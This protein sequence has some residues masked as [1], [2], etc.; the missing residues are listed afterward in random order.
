MKIRIAYLLTLVGLAGFA[1]LPAGQAAVASTL[2]VDCA[3]DSGALAAAL[4]SA[5]DGD[6]LAIQGVCKGAF[7]IAHSLTLAGGAA[8]TLDGQG[9]GTVLSID[10]GNSVVVRNL[11]ITGGHDASAGGVRNAG[12]LSLANSRVS[13]NSAN[14][15]SGAAFFAAGGILNTGALAVENSI[16]T[17]NSTSG[18]NFGA[19]AIASIAGSLRLTNS[20]VSGNTATVLQ[21]RNGVAGIL[22]FSSNAIVM[23]SA[24]RGNIASASDR[25]ST[26]VGGI[27]NASFNTSVP[28]SFKLINST[29]SDNSATGAPSD[30]IGGILNS[31]PGGVVSLQNSAV[32]ENTASAPGGESAFSI[33]VGGIEN[34]GG[35]LSLANSSVRGNSASEPSG[36]FLPPVGGIANYFGGAIAALTN[37]KVTNNTPNNCNF[38]DP[39]CTT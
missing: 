2:R 31:G 32:R 25:F 14:G 8:A 27:D 7:E 38:S 1:L 16:V 28:S 30:A 4:A 12:T 5:S 15:A 22:S 20:S 17:A 23:N 18:A 29:V 6:T 37:S 11:L 39:A 3:T 34:G 19:A 36:G 10:A 26:A 33:A 9:A 35:S 21:F 24:I 13:G